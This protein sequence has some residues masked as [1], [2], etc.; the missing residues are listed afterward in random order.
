[1]ENN[2]LH[3]LLTSIILC[4]FLWNSS[5][6]DTA[7]NQDIDSYNKS[8]N[9]KSH[10]NKSEKIEYHLN[11]LKEEMPRLDL[12]K[13]PVNSESAIKYFEYY[14]LN[15]KNTLHYFGSFNSKQ[16]I[17]A[18]HVFLPD[19]PAG[20]VLL[21]HGYLDHSGILKNLISNCLESGYAVAVFDLPGHGLSSGEMA[22]VDDFSEYIS[23]LDDFLKKY[24]SVLPEPLNLIGHSTGCS[25]AFD[26]LSKFKDKEIS[27]V[28]FL[29]P[30]V[31]TA[32]WETFK[33]GYY[34][35]GIFFK[36]FKRYF[37]N[38]SR[39]TEYI[40][41]IKNDPLQAREI[42]VKWLKALYLWNKRVEKYDVLSKRVLIIQGDDDATVDWKYN[43][44]FF[45]KKVKPLEV[46]MIKN[47]R[48][49]LINEIVPERSIV[50]DI[51]NDE[52]EKSLNEGIK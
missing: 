48:H 42:P 44:E 14:G 50:F 29:S 4:L 8:H 9:N 47:A 46:K 36:K 51:I 7:G 18:G 23:A 41:F 43:I 15:F 28:I 6:A 52:L 40:E 12:S 39:D 26:Y 20:T 16:K 34:F 27:K 45:R 37:R 31:H 5:L 13:K 21:L 17:I 10:N 25:V 30:L 3:R 24:Y 1:M 2:I 19:N 22:S 32:Y 38:N 49:Q 35:F 33:T 11:K